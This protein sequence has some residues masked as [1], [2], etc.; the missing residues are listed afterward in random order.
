MKKI[1][2]LSLIFGIISF[3]LAIY[4]FTALNA[5]SNDPN[6][7]IQNE[8]KLYAILFTV[9]MLAA[10]IITIAKKEKAIVVPL[11]GFVTAGI[12]FVKKLETGIQ[13]N[14][15]ILDLISPTENNSVL[16]F[17]LFITFIAFVFV[18]VI[19]NTNWSKYYVIGY[20]ALLIL[21][22]FKFLPDIT[23][24]DDM[25]AYTIISYSMI[26]GYIS[27]LSFFIPY[28]EKV[29]KENEEKALVK[30]ESKEDKKEI[31]E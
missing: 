25:K 1:K 2:V 6:Y 3:V 31:A 19:K 24:N 27:L 7:Q 11:L 14:N 16:T 5:D 13:G 18:S 4:S 10:V 17:L 9:F 26:A 12:Y 15:S 30:E 20:F 23:L 29:K 8:F 21:S 22:T 28:K